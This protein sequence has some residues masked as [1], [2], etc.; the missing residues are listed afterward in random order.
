M[1]AGGGELWEIAMLSAR[2]HAVNFLAIRDTE[3][4]HSFIAGVPV[5]RSIG[6]ARSGG[7]DQGGHSK[8]PND[9]LAQMM[10]RDRIFAPGLLRLSGASV[11]SVSLEA[12]PE[13]AATAGRKK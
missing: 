5:V 2:D 3:A 9:Q 8:A 4:S 7:A 12:D 11:V 13:V 6:D 10:G 1:L